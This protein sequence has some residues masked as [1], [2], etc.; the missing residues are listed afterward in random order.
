M[1]RGGK[2]TLTEWYAGIGRVYQYGTSCAETLLLNHRP[3][4]TSINTSSS[5]SSSIS[6]P[7][8]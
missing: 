6:E 8:S 1:G 7:G 3:R 4:H 2:T 5:S